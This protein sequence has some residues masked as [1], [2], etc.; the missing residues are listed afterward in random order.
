MANNEFEKHAI[1]R[2]SM[3]APYGK[4][5]FIDLD[6]FDPLLMLENTPLGNSTERFHTRTTHNGVS[7]VYSH[8]RPLPNI[9][10]LMLSVSGGLEEVQQT[11]FSK[12]GDFL[13]QYSG[14]LNWLHISP[15][16]IPPERNMRIWRVDLSNQQ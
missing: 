6:I 15:L 10:L 8:E 11:I 9:E 5:H 7:I 4:A 1:R 13:G 12:F 2:W 3:Q 14:Q 16:G